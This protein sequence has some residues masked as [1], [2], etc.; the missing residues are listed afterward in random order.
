MIN[1]QPPPEWEAEAELASKSEGGKLRAPAIDRLTLEMRDDGLMYAPGA[2]KPFTGKDVEPLLGG[3][4][5]QP[6]EG[7]S[8]VWPYLDGKIH[9]AKE[10]Y[11]SNGRLREARIYEQG[12]AKQSTVNFPSGKKKLFAKLN[13]KDVAEGEYKR[14]YE[15][16]QLHTEGAHDADERFQGEFKEYDEHG[17]MTG[18]YLWEHGKLM[19]IFFET[20]EQKEHRL[21]N[22]GKLEGEA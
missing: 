2:E 13:A 12:I 21:K 20:P 11:F 3:N 22:Y 4:P 10:T 16:G 19:K 5:P 1:C 9:G 17:N 8:V 6:R 7:F 14:W 18:H 15:N